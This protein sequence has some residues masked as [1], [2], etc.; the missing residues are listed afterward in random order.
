MFSSEEDI[1]KKI[2]LAVDRPD[3]RRKRVKT[4]RGSAC[5]T[6][7]HVIVVGMRLTTMTSEIRSFPDCSCN[8]TM[9]YKTAPSSKNT[10][11]IA[12][13]FSF[14]KSAH[15]DLSNDV[16]SKKGDEAL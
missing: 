8:T 9:G 1:A 11:L 4:L 15:L 3:N 6:V 5:V 12:K 10:P 16:K 14:S 13:I 2:G 7:D